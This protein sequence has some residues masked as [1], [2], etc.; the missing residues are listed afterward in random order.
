MVPNISEE[1]VQSLKTL[2]P[3]H[4]VAFGNAFKIP[5]NLKIDIPNPQPKSSNSDIVKEWYG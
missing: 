4:A 3:G 1:I 2:Q 5:M